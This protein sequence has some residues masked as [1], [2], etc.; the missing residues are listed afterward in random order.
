MHMTGDARAQLREGP[1]S[2]FQ[3]MIVVITTALNMIDGFDVLAISFTAPLIAREWVVTPQPLGILLSAGLAGMALGSLFLSPVADILGRRAVLIASTAV[4]SVGMLASAVTGNVLELA[5]C[6]L[7]TG[8]GVGG[9]LAS[10]NTL[11][12]EYSSERWRDLSISTMVVGYSAGA[13]VGGSISAYLIAAFGWRAAFIFG[14]VCSTV[15]LPA[16]F[17][18]PESL[19]FILAS[20]AKNPL[21][22]ANQVLRGAGAPENT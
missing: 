15:L 10:G 7:L 1:M 16:V 21:S 17:V 8:I 5:V 11:L 20:K 13:I 22:R 18:L 9:V 12:A 14:G 4:L 3:I 6:R 19:D 2:S